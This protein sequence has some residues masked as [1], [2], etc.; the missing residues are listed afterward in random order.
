MAE[1]FEIFRPGSLLFTRV[2]ETEAFGTAFSLAARLRKPLSFLGTGQQIPDD[3]EPATRE[4]VLDLLW[5]SHPS[6]ASRA[7]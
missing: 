1:R 7:A 3:L 2:D 4:A 5:Q 6:A